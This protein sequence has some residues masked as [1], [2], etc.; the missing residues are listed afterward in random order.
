MLQGTVGQSHLEYN[1][2]MQKKELPMERKKNYMF[3]N[4]KQSEKGIM[5]VV[6]GMISLV[7]VIVVIYQTYLYKGAAGINSGLVGF[8][9]TCFAVTGVILGF[10]ARME[11]DRFLVFAYVGIVLNIVVLGCISLI[12]YAG[13]YGIG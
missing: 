11:T 4:K 1:L 9:V 13:A 12:L 6:L 2:E 7:S 5:S 8:W 10:M 3:T